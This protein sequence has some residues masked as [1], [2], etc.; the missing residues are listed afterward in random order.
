MHRES[1]KEHGIA[2]FLLFVPVVVLIG[3]IVGRC[4][5]A[6]HHSGDLGHGRHCGGGPRGHLGHGHGH[7]FQDGRGPGPEHES[8]RRG[9]DPMRILDRRFAKGE[10]DEDEYQR[11][12]NVLKENA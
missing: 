10:I 7:G 12:R 5:N 4:A 11:R 8:R 2:G 9:F 1:C 3:A 6:R